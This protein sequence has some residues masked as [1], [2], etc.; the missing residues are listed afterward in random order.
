ML[1]QVCELWLAVEMVGM[2][3]YQL[4]GDWLMVMTQLSDVTA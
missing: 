1:Q 2:F 4:F 3:L